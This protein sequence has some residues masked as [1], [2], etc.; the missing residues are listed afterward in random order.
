M[1]WEFDLTKTR[2]IT[3][4]ECARKAV[5]KII[6]KRLS[7]ILVK[8]N[9]LK[10]GNHAGLPGSN[11]AAPLRIICNIIEDAKTKNKELWILF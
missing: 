7:N 8:H 3:L 10:G 5:V 1:D 11:T 9:I 2:P 6:A 4:L